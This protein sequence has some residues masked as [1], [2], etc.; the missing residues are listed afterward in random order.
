VNVPNWANTDIIDAADLVQRSAFPDAVAD[1]IPVA[2][3]LVAVFGSGSSR[4][5]AATVVGAESI[6]SCSSTSAAAEP[7]APQAKIIDGKAVTPVEHYTI[8]AT[9]GEVGSWARYHT[10]LDFAAPIGT[11]V[12]AALAGTISH[13]GFG[14]AAGSWAGDYVTIK[15]AGGTSTLY[16]H[17]SATYVAEGQLVM[18]GERIGAIGITGRS[19]GPHLHFETYPEGVQ[20]GDIY[21]AIDPAR[22]L[23]GRGVQES[24]TTQGSAG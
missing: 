24:I 6:D 10:G 1:D 9:F 2:R 22:W 17:M 18:T 12:R 14:G 11:P 8:T 16:A 3:K 20:P 4:G 7:G 13:V 15:H 21:R 23:A 5:S 19:F